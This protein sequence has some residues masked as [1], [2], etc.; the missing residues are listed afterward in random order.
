M[1]MID[2]VTRGSPSQSKP[3]QKPR[4]RPPGTPINLLCTCC[5]VGRRKSPGLDRRAQYVTGCRRPRQSE[6]ATNTVVIAYFIDVQ[7]TALLHLAAAVLPDVK[8]ERILGMAEPFNWDRILAILR[9]QN[10]GRE[11]H[12]NFTDAGYSV[13]VKPRDRA[14]H[15]LRELGRPGWT[16]LE[17]SILRN[18]ED[19]RDAS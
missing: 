17:D 13:T 12:K 7:D 19:L 2:L 18:T 11:F 10:P 8:S 14:E 1:R 6:H 5:L 15:L 3:R 4:P 16:S 9:K